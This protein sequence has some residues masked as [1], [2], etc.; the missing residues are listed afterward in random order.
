MARLQPAQRRLATNVRFVGAD[1]VVEDR[2]VARSGG[3]KRAHESCHVQDREW[4]RKQLK[5][6][7]QNRR[8]ALAEAANELDDAKL[9]IASA[10]EVGI[11]KTEIARLIAVSMPT[12][13]ALLDE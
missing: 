3:P 13:Y 8:R 10:V 7:G 5:A 4:L 9:L 1:R 6:R 12:L 11:T 2:D